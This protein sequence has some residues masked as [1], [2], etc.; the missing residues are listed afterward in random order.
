MVRKTKERTFMTEAAA[1]QEGFDEDKDE[2]P[3]G[4]KGAEGERKV[5]GAPKSK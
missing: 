2:I 1:K 5:D 4:K 3:G